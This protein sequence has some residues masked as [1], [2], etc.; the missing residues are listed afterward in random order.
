MSLAGHF[1]DAQTTRHTLTEL[2]AQV[3]QS[4]MIVRPT[5]DRP[6]EEALALLDEQI[7]Y[8]SVTMMHQ[9]IFSELPIFISVGAMPLACC[10]MRL[11]CKADG[12]SGAVESPQFLDEAIVELL[13]P[14]AAAKSN[15]LLSACQKFRAIT[16]FDIDGISE[17]DT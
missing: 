7:I 12:Y 11:I 17:R 5:S 4:G 6:V 13:C 1:G 10:I 14:F 9:P 15:D 8:G 3:T 2:Q 16:P